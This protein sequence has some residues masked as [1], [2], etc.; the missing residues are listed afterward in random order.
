MG[1]SPIDPLFFSLQLRIGQPLWR[2]PVPWSGCC[3]GLHL[4]DG[5]T[6]SPSPP[7]YGLNGTRKQL[8]LAIAVSGR[9]SPWPSPHSCWEQPSFYGMG[10]GE[11]PVL[12]PQFE[13]TL[14]GHELISGLAEDSVV[15][16]SQLNSTLHPVLLLSFPCQ[17]RLLA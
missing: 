7:E 3:G 14:K 6:C 15:A 8:S 4:L 17:H 13:K 10:V 12:L 2:H 16:T 11:R 5:G 1:R 9:Q